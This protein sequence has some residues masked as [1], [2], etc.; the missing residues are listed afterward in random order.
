MKGLALCAPSE[1]TVIQVQNRKARKHCGSLLRVKY[2]EDK[3]AKLKGQKKWGRWPDVQY[4][5]IRA[6]TEVVCEY[7]FV[8]LFTFGLVHFGKPK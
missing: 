7:L 6:Q 4:Y 3:H 1:L 2:D 5:Y 8:S